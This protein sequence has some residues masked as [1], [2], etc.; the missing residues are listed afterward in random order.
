MAP[1]VR[2]SKVALQKFWAR[3][4]MSKVIQSFSVGSSGTREGSMGNILIQ[5]HAA[6]WARPWD[7][8][9]VTWLGSG[10]LPS[11]EKA[12]G[13]CSAGPHSRFPPGYYSPMGPIGTIFPFSTL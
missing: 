6:L 13:A 7:L 10:L 9:L 12:V 8:C 11:E 5:L 2:P 1:N 4:G 3:D